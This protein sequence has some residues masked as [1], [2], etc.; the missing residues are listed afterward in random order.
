MPANITAAKTTF[1]C[2]ATQRPDNPAWIK[3]GE[4]CDQLVPDLELAQ[5]VRGDVEQQPR[6]HDEDNVG[7]GTG[8]V[9]DQRKLSKRTRWDTG[10]RLRRPAV[11]GGDLRCSA[12]GTICPIVAGVEEST[13]SFGD[14][15]DI[16]A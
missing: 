7:G 10:A 16:L 6:R 12:S 11:S 13:L 1:Q 9:H 8:S 2:S 15:G 5:I 4:D 14:Q 3:N